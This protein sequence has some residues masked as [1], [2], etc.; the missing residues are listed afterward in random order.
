LAAA[1]VVRADDGANKAAAPVRVTI[2]ATKA[3]PP[4]N[5][6]IYGQFIQHLGR[7]IYGGRWAPVLA[8]RE[9]SCP[10]TAKRAPYAD[11]Q[12]TKFPVLTAS[13]WQATGPAG[14]VTMET[15]KP[16][17]G[18]HSLKFTH[19][20]GIEQHDLG[21]VAN[22]VYDGYVRVRTPDGQAR[23]TVALSWGKGEN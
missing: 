12:D 5:P 11:L 14:S 8:G 20:G 13:P 21:L 22:Q 4:I 15:A 23:L 2:C 18:E 10:A 1:V 17:S 9:F 3:G 16:L 6:F 19:G 7:C